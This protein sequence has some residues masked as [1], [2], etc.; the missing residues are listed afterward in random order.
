MVLI[1]ESEGNTPKPL[2]VAVSKSLKTLH[3]GKITKEICGILDGK[4]GGRPDFAQ[5]SVGNLDKLNAAK[6]KFY[7]LL[8]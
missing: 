3:A 6:D 5:G 1:G 4:G 8:E 7:E 2:I